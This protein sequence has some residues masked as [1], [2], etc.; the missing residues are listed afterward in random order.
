MEIELSRN[1]AWFKV[2]AHSPTVISAHKLDD[3]SASEQEHTKL[4]AIV[5]R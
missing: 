3:D 2:M 4:I 1:F 5:E